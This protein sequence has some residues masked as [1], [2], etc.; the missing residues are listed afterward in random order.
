[1]FLVALSFLDDV[2]GL[3]ATWRFIAQ[4]AAAAVFLACGLPVA[5]ETVGWGVALLTLVWMANLYNFMDGADGLAGG[6]ALFGFSGYAA[7]SPAIGWRLAF[8]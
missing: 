1:L 5:P 2:Y 7:E 6:M 4:F 3:S 8:S